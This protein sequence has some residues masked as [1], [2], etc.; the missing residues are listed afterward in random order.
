[1]AEQTRVSSYLGNDLYTL[2]PFWSDAL[3]CFDREVNEDLGN[4]SALLKNVPVAIFGTALLDPGKYFTRASRFLPSM[5]SD[6]V[7]RSWTGSA[8]TLLLETSISFVQQTISFS[9][10]LFGSGHPHIRMLDFGIGWGRIARL[11]LKYLPP[12]QVFGCDAWDKSLILARECNLKNTIVKS[13]PLLKELPFPEGFFDM[14]YSMSV[15][16][17]LNEEAFRSCL[18]GIWKMLKPSGGLLISVRPSIFWQVL[19]PDYPSSSLLSKDQGFVFRHGSNDPNFG[20]STVGLEWVSKA[21]SSC[22]YIL[23]GIEWSPGD[24]MQVLVRLVKAE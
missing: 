2:C 4:S 9:T 16:T 20:D 8:G 13:D 15:F 21:A 12:S 19:R 23:E 22:G 10:A 11:L 6:Q 1:M 17:H 18:A 14:V 3:K 7:Q 5:P 24:A